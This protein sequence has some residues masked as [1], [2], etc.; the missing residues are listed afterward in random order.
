MSKASKLRRTVTAILLVVGLLLTIGTLTIDRF[1]VG[2]T[3]QFGVLQM[4]GL[5]LGITALTAAAYL[6]MGRARQRGE[7]R[8]LQADIGFRLS[9]TGLVLTYVAGYADLIGIGT[10]IGPEFSRPFVGPLQS[11]GM[12]LGIV[13]IIS[14]IVLFYTSRG[15]RP[16][17]SL[18][19]LLNGRRQN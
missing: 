10:H 1:G 14:G 5:L 2:R 4:L 7:L 18:E 3:P 12:V 16:S 19:F 8:S 6:A 15:S 11:A 13:L 9:A 17:S